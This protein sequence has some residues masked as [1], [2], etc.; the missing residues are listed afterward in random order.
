[1]FVL[2][3]GQ[4]GSF[5]LLDSARFNSLLCPSYRSFDLVEKSKLAMRKKESV[6][7]DIPRWGSLKM[8]Q[9]LNGRGE[10][11]SSEAVEVVVCPQCIVKEREKE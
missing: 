11:K 3:S 8:R 10:R 5:S 7:L 4:N 9:K 1:M 6:N 2:V